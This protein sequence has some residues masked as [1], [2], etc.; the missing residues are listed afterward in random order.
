MFYPQSV[1]FLFVAAEAIYDLR[2]PAPGVAIGFLGLAAVVMTARAANAGRPENSLWILIATALFIVESRAIYHDRADN[3]SQQEITRNQEDQRFENAQR[4][5][6][7]HFLAVL[8]ESQGQFQVTMKASNTIIA[9]ASRAADFA[10][11]G[12]SFPTIFPYIV[13]LENG[14]KEI[15]FSLGKSGTY[16]LYEVSVTCG[17][18]YRAS[19]ENNSTEIIGA[20]YRKAEYN[21]ASNI[22]I[23]FQPLPQE[24]VAYYMAIMSARNGHWEEVI[25]ARAMVKD[26]MVFRWVI[27]G[28]DVPYQAPNKL[29]SDLVSGEFPPSVR[30][31]KIYPLDIKLLPFKAVAS[32]RN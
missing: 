8:K 10:S 21:D 32:A 12:S 1:L 27:Y 2:M 18:P 15:G 11:G 25:E 29:L 6:N 23:L 30:H 16:P 14:A 17:R 7:Q 4:E 22:P 20:T 24:P 31:A 19:A 28:T 13:T 3:E 5:E 9:K 26:S